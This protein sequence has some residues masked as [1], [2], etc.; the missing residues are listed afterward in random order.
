MTGSVPWWR[1]RRGSGARGWGRPGRGGCWGRNLAST[2]RGHTDGRRR[3]PLP[4]PPVPP[5]ERVGAPPRK[6]RLVEETGRGRDHDATSRKSRKEFC[7]RQGRGCS[8]SLGASS[9]TFTSLKV[10]TLTF[11]ANRAGRYMSHTHASVIDTSKNTSPA[12]VRA[13]TSTWLHR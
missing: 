9:S 1:S 10:S 3:W 6:S 11:L 7:R 12:S 13:F 8:R 5:G 2:Q 4:V